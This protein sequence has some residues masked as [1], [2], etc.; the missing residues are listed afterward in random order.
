MDTTGS[1]ALQ[2]NNSFEKEH[3]GKRLY[4]DAADGLNPFRGERSTNAEGEN[5]DEALLRAALEQLPTG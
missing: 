1:L 3:G 4:D 2:G 5:D